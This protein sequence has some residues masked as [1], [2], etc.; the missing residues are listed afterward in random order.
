MYMYCNMF[1]LIQTV[2]VTRCSLTP[3]RLD[4]STVDQAFGSQKRYLS[5]YHDYAAGLVNRCHSS[6]G[7][8]SDEMSCFIY[9]GS[10]PR[11][12]GVS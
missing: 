5:V 2:S 7:G 1:H 3:E 11:P 10:Y 12:A 6:L 9:F 4:W 8:P